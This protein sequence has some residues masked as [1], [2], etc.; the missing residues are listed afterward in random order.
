[1]IEDVKY[2]AIKSCGVHP[3]QKHFARG[4]NRNRRKANGLCEKQTQKNRESE[5][6]NCSANDKMKSEKAI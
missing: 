2:P 5:R 6:Q 4:L 1:M 3:E